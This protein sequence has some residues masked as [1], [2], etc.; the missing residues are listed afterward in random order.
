[1]KR[2]KDFDTFENLSKFHSKLKAFTI[3]STEALRPKKDRM[4][5]RF[6]LKEKRG[7]GK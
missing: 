6:L 7:W 4:K 3:D 5:P 1:M 2:S